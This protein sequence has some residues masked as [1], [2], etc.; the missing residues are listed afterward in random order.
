MALLRVQAS[1]EQKQKQDF[2]VIKK[3]NDNN[4]TYIMSTIAM[5]FHTSK[6]YSPSLRII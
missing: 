1:L 3:N 6:L 5:A 4:S 2:H